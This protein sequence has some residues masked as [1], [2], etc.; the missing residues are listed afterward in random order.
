MRR[1]KPIYKRFPQFDFAPLLTDGLDQRDAALAR[2]IDKAV[3]RR[4]ISLTT[5][6]DAATERNVRRLDGSVGAALLVGA[7]QLFL[8]DRIP[9]HAIINA[10]VEWVKQESDNKRAAG[11][12]NAVLRKL[13]RI[14]G[15]LVQTYDASNGHHL[16]RTDG[17]AYVMTEPIFENDIASATGFEA[18]VWERL[19]TKFG[20]EQAT[21]IALNA[22][23]E[24][25]TIVIM[26]IGSPPL[27]DAEP[28]ETNNCYVLPQGVHFA[29]FLSAYPM[30]RIQDPTSA[31]SL[32]LCEL[33]RPARILDV[34]AGKG[35]KTKQLR[36]MFPDAF[37]AATEPNIARREVLQSVADEYD[38]T[39][40]TEETAG[41]SEPFDLVVVDAPCSNSGVFARRPEAKY[42]YKEKTIDALVELQREILRESY[43][44]L[45][46]GGHLLYAT[47]SIDAEENESQV[48]WLADKQRLQ[49]V[50]RNRT[51][52]KGLP[53]EYA[54]SWHDG[55]FSALLSK[56]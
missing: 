23:I 6:I 32:S 33:L 25:P 10:S 17:S 50:N 43:D 49:C 54:S 28:H 42:R 16:L 9:D 40:Y 5:I 34:C 36:S 12:V 4:W 24:P 27:H 38:V 44:V 18:K 7:A 1:I 41:P 3:L 14:R 39:V 31:H 29:D 52:P 37:I 22:I 13:T 19:K 48:Q 51:M 35:T 2:A 45:K 20:T 53:G 15:E 47:C 55:G 56:G 21:S 11:F 30:A 26:P 46:S 8:F